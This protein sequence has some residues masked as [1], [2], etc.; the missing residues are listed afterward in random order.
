VSTL[1]QEL[2]RLYALPLSEFTR[3]RN[4]A[5]SRLR[6]AGDAEAAEEL[7]KLRKP[8][9]A[10]WA[11]N[12]AARRNRD[13]LGDVLA[14]GEE[15][16]AAQADALGG[17]GGASLPEASRREREAIAKLVDSAREILEADTGQATR[18]TLD[19]IE[20]T[21]RTAA[22]DENARHQLEQ[23][24]LSEDLEPTGFG[25]FLGAVPTTKEK[26]DPRGDERKEKVEQARAT[27]KETQARERELRK[28][29]AEAER[30]ALGAR[31]A[32]ELAEE[33]ARKKAD[34]AEAAAEQVAA[35]EGALEALVKR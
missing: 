9:A 14:A 35:A 25:P 2:D 21:L 3:A 30:E 33:R 11:I 5:A 18:Q 12:Q 29:A 26:R 32:A 1:E 10:A 23:S 24:R 16:R 6:K 27:L 7:K 15:L 28:A 17:G 22:V 4:A 31:R 20:A 8:T 34:E 19:K 13:E